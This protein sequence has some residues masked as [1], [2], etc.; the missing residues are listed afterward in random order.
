MK[1]KLT[2]RKFK[3][4]KNAACPLCKPWKRGH[5]GKRKPSEIRESI[6]H[7]QQLKEV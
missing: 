1:T 3:A 4:D 2:Q 5:A 7:D 6:S